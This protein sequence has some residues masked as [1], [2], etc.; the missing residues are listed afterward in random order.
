MLVG[1]ILRQ[2]YKIVRLLGSGSFGVTY[3]AED[4][5][6]PDHPLCV[7]KNLKQSQNLK[8][9]EVSRRLFD[10][11]AKVL[12]ILG[13]ECDQ[14]PR[15]YAHF[16]ENEEFYLVQEFIDGHDLSQEIFPGKKWSEAD[17]VQLLKEILEILTLVHNQ[18]VI[19]RDIK[20]QNLMRRH[21]DNKIVLIDFGA[22]KEITGMAINAQG[23]TASTMIVGT[24]GYMPVEQLNGYPKLSSDI[25]AVGMVGIYALTGIKPQD[26]PKDPDSF[27]IIWRDQASVS[28]QLAN[29]L[30]K[31]VRYDFSQRY[32]TAVLALQDLTLPPPSSPLLLLTSRVQELGLNQKVLIAAGVAGAMLFGVG[33]L[34][35]NFSNPPIP[36]SEQVTSEAPTSE[37]EAPTSEL[38]AP[39]SES[40][41]PTSEAELQVALVCPEIPFPSF[42]DKPDWEI[43]GT[44]YYDFP[45]KERPTGKGV[46]IYPD[47]KGGYIQYHGE[48]NNGELSG[49]GTYIFPS[50]DRYIGQFDK[51]KF[52][53]IGKFI[54]T[55]GC[56]YIGEFSENKF[57]GSGVWI[58]KEGS[59]H[60]GIWE[61]GKLKGTNEAFT[62]CQ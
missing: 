61:K 20:T 49:C 55:Q 62:T 6:L 1:Q 51:N 42:P 60:P 34:L 25:Y 28:P 7:V 9:L 26:L 29:V 22:V 18:N 13:N 35:M 31:M 12:Y 4:F 46:M 16:E 19:H 54:F 59:R 50:G 40:L 57:D 37:L 3:L 30:N 23:Q 53:G 8:Y 52:H 27:E 2:R 24:Y 41:P 36:E 48:L 5:D 32:Q 15:L 33:L 17:V 58:S 38:E 44:K 21:T 14:I 10:R 11:E 39:T 43:N 56:Q 45:K 47:S